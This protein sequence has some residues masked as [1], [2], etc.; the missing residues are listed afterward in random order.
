M[1]FRAP[2]PRNFI[3]TGKPNLT[4]PEYSHDADISLNF[5]FNNLYKYY[6]FVVFY[7]VHDKIT[8][9]RSTVNCG[10]LVFS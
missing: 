2:P 6:L 5:F 9:H 7:M 1:K 3:E 4:P 10:R 8:P